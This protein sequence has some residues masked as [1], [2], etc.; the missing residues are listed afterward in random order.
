MSFDSVE[1][2][3]SNGKIWKHGIVWKEAKPRIRGKGRK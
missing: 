1:E 3:I 2:A